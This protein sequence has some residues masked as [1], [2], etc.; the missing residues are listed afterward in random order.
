MPGPNARGFLSE[1]QV[2][3]GDAQLVTQLV[4]GSQVLLGHVLG[5][6]ANKYG[7]GRVLSPEAVQACFRIFHVSAGRGVVTRQPSRGFD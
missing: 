3:F 6:A 5:A 2:L 1:P 7:E 4:P